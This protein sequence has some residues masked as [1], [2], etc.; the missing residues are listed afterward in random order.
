VRRA[1]GRLV[2]VGGGITGLCAAHTWCTMSID[3]G[4]P[5]DV[6]VVEQAHRW[7]GLIRTIVRDGCTVEC[8]PD[9]LLLNKRGLLSWIRTLGLTDALVPQA[10]D[11]R[12]V[13]VWGDG[14]HVL[15]QKMLLGVPLQPAALDA[16]D[17]VD[18]AGKARA[19]AEQ[20]APFVPDGDVSLG[21]LLRARFGAPWTDAVMRPLLGGIH[22]CSIDV[23]SAQA[24][25][26]QLWDAL[27]THGSMIRALRARV[28]EDADVP[29]QCKGS[30]FVSVHGGLETI[31]DA[32]V[33]D[34]ERFGCTMRLGVDAQM[35]TRDAAAVIVTAPPWHVALAHMPRIGATGVAYVVLAYDA[36]DVALRAGSGFVAQERPER[37]ITACTW[38]SQKWPHTAPPSRTLLRCYV[39]RR[40]DTRWMELDDA[41]LA[42]AVRKDVAQALG[43]VCPPLWTHVER[44]YDALPHYAP[45]HI[46]RVSD[47]RKTLSQHRTYIVGKAYD[48]VGIPDCMRNAADTAIEAWHAVHA[49]RP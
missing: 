29:E 24:A 49:P 15:P 40:H 28:P 33:R 38:T 25:F 4:V 10:P 6:V 23:L 30:A 45:G 44:L 16:V 32:L 37:I 26:P 8:G 35:C 19:W 48:G 22:A 43:I 31:V 20:D 7:G 21:A 47:A 13:Y 18:D 12:T 27:H 14:L 46:A 5:V 1:V 9:A 36:R 2:V 39:G 34:L 11:G 42:A 41:A 3:A 17:W